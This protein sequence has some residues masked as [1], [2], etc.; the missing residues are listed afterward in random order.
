MTEV[1]GSAVALVLV[2]ERKGAETLESEPCRVAVAFVAVEIAVAVAAALFQV[3]VA[4]ALCFW[5]GRQPERGS[6]ALKQQ[7]PKPKP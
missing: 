4:S 5:R 2:G 6:Q 1:P 7:K 3:S